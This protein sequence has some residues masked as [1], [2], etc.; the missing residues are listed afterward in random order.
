MIPT[1][2]TWRNPYK[3][4]YT[5]DEFD[6]FVV[7]GEQFGKVD[8]RVVPP[9]IGLSSRGNHDRVLDHELRA[10]ANDAANDLDI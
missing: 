5:K 7:S 6:E 10:A 4:E 2:R 3:L 9:L 8:V 1:S